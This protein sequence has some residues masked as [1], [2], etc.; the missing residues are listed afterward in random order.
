METEFVDLDYLYELERDLR[1]DKDFEKDM[2]TMSESQ[3]EEIFLEQ[4]LEQIREQ[5]E[6]D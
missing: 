3:A 4:A 5:R 1:A 6:N 2:I